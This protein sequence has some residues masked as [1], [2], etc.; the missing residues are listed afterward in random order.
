MVVLE[1]QHNPQLLL[2]FLRQCLEAV[3]W[4]PVDPYACLKD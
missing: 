4:L 2:L 1:I 3:P